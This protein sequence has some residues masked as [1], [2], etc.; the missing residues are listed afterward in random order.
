MAN[1]GFMATAPGLAAAVDG[2]APEVETAARHGLR[3]VHLPLHYKG[4][5]DEILGRLV[6]TFREMPGPFYVHC[7]HGR[8][9]G[10]AAA[11]IG[12]LVLDG[13]SRE[14]ALAEMRQ[15]CGTSNSY[16]GL[17]GSI[18]RAE[19]PSV[20][21]SAK[22]AWDFPSRHRVQALRASMA[23]LARSLD[24]L[25]LSE[26]QGWVRSPAHPDLEP[27]RA[28]AHM[29]ELLQ[30]LALLEE[31]RGWDSDQRQWIDNCMDAAEAL[32]Q[33]VATNDFN[34]RDKSFILRS[35]FLSRAEDALS[36]LSDN[37]IACHEANR[38]R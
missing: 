27:A 37:C 4:I 35:T 7:F 16:P 8:H 2:K 29:V 12:R 18:A 25:T 38:N 22:L 26:E 17:Y 14:T 36:R 31:V 28:V 1:P 5:E 30:G 23:N 34:P 19:L 3:Y 32:T 10:P 9:R 24:D 15:W 20:E 13:A 6:K 11:A 21:Q 33:V